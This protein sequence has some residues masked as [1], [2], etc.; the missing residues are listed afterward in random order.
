M[1]LGP[2]LPALTRKALHPDA[3]KFSAFSAL[4]DMEDATDT[5]VMKQES[6]FSEDVTRWIVPT[7]ERAE[8]S[9]RF[10]LATDVV[11]A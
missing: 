1:G 10:F 9:P 2:C 8:Q 4:P 11:F 7:Q 6:D 5:H 3:S